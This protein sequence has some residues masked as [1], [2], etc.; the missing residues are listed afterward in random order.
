MR[1]QLMCTR[2]IFLAMYNS[3]Q[4]LERNDLY[5]T[6]CLFFLPR[7]A[8]A[9]TS[10]LYADLF[11]IAFLF[12]NG[13]RVVGEPW[14]LKTFVIISRLNMTIYFT[15]RRDV[16]KEQ[17]TLFNAELRPVSIR[18]ILAWHYF[19]EKIPIRNKKQNTKNKW[20]K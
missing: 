10:C 18:S 15:A 12:W 1:D 3:A 6:L 5:M 2:H 19:Y 20:D 11:V 13:L 9:R 7:W 14:K 8:T 4:T 16:L 17:N